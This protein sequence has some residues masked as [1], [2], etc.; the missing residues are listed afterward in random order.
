MDGNYD[1]ALC[2]FNYKGDVEGE[3]Y[4]GEAKVEEPVPTGGVDAAEPEEKTAW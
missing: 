1:A 4:S 2:G 3:G